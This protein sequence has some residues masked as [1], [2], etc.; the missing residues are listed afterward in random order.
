[1]PN[2]FQLLLGISVLIF[3]VYK[4]SAKAF[5]LRK[6]EALAGSVS[7]VTNLTILST[8]HHDKVDDFSDSSSVVSVS[9]T[10]SR[11]RLTAD[12]VHNA[13]SIFPV[14]EMKTDSGSSSGLTGTNSINEIAYP[15]AVIKR[16]IAMMCVYIVFI[17]SASTLERCSGAYWTVYFLCFAPLSLSIYFGKLVTLFSYYFSPDSHEMI[18][19]LLLYP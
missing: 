12:N 17:A 11:S 6:M 1:M 15:W 8:M 16:I 13:E 4:T 3:V 9:T 18:N 10:A 14:L 5:E 7:S 19:E 2:L